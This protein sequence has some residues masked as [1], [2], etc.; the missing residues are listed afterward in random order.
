VGRALYSGN[1]RGQIIGDLSGLVKLVFSPDD[2]RLL[3]VHVLGEMAS[4]L[5][6]VGQGC[7][8]FGGGIDYFIEAVFNYPRW[9][10]V[11]TLPTTASA[12]GRGEVWRP[13]SS[14]E[15]GVL[16]RTPAYSGRE[17]PAGRW[18]F[19]GMP[20]TL[21]AARVIPA[22]AARANRTLFRQRHRVDRA[23]PAARCAGC[24][25]PAG[26]AAFA[27]RSTA[28]VAEELLARFVEDRPLR[29]PSIFCLGLEVP[30]VESRP[31]QAG[32]NLG[33]DD[34]PALRDRDESASPTPNSASVSAFA[35]PVGCFSDRTRV[36]AGSLFNGSWGTTTA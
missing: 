13:T 1:S 4:E 24:Y 5:V 19:R 36:Y 12:P 8:H 2:R 34:G 15:Q 16:R 14:E 31:L 32:G 30:L 7:L 3:G 28:Q 35:E 29:L 11:R 23:G 6:H 26:S 25:F 22:A 17:R 21:L 9:Q 10:V 20:L 27:V 18:L 33:A